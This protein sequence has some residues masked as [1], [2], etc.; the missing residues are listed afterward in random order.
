MQEGLDL[1]RHALDR[2]CNLADTVLNAVD[3]TV[4]DV[5]A[6]LERLRCK[7]LDEVHRS[8]EAVFNSG[9]YRSDL[10]RYS[11]FYAIPNR[12]NH[13]FNGV[14]DIDDRAFDVIPDIC[15][16]CKN[17]VQDTADESGYSVPHR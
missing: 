5:S 11:R 10:V 9:F 4:D 17:C 2:I 15:D 14:Q 6:P 7:V 8:I 3:D 1:V 12:S 16:C 13:S